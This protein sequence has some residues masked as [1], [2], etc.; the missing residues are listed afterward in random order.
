[1]S[2]GYLNQVNIHGDLVDI[3]GPIS[4]TDGSECAE[5][6]VLYKYT[7]Y[8][9]ISYDEYLKFSLYGGN[10]QKLL[11]AKVGDRILVHGKLR[12]SKTGGV[13]V[14]AARIWIESI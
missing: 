7:S 8:N 10:V 14:L 12:T 4:T 6:V 1:M 5:G 2:S 3:I 13:S 9:G 11:S